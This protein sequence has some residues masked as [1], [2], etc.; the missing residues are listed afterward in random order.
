[1]EVDHDSKEVFVEELRTIQN[2]VPAARSVLV[3]SEEAI[4]SRLTSPIVRT[5]LETEKISFERYYYRLEVMLHVLKQMGQEQERN[6][7]LEVRQS[8]NCKWTRV[9]SI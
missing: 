5:F 3:P 1:M 8:G 7:G 2:D 9:Q 6:L 4:K